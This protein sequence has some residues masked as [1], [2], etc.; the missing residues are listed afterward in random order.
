VA[1]F[2]FLWTT[3]T[4][5]NSTHIAEEQVLFEECLQPFIAYTLVSPLLSKSKDKKY[6]EL[7]GD[8]KVSVHLVIT[9]QKTHKNTVF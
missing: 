4:S 8:Q 9:V 1:V 2:K 5:D 3:L 6:I 7:Q